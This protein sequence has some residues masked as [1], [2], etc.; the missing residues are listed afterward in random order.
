ML[1]SSYISVTFFFLLSCASSRSITISFSDPSNFLTQPDAFDLIATVK[2]V[3]GPNGPLDQNHDGN[4]DEFIFPSTCTTS[5]AAG[6][7]LPLAQ[8]ADLDLGKLPNGWSYKIEVI[9]RKN[10]G[11]SGVIANGC[12]PFSTTSSTTTIPIVLGAYTASCL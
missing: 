9:I 4:P 5:F 3:A 7:G 2:N 11:N 12:A 8:A 1:R 6:C 10:T